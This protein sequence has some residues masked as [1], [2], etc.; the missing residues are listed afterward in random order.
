MKIKTE[1]RKNGTKRV[2]YDYSDE[3]C[4]TDQAAA[5]ELTM[6]SIQAKIEKGI[7]P[8]LASDLRYSNDHGLR[9]FQ[10]VF[11]RTQEVKQLYEQLP[12]AIRQKM[13]NDI[14]NFESVI[15]DPQNAQLLLDH[16]LLI[17]EKDNHKELITAING[18]KSPPDDQK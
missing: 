6:A 1:I 14:R 2:S 8:Q 10:D 3:K 13:G 15:F 12:T 11:D 16:G 4:I 18:L 7:M 17:E 5:S 9:N